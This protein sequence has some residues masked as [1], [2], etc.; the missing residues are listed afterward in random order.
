MEE[1]GRGH[2]WTQTPGERDFESAF[3]PFCFW[4]QCAGI[5]LFLMQGKD[6][7]FQKWFL[8]F[9][10]KVFQITSLLPFELIYLTFCH[11][12]N[13]LIHYSLITKK[14]KV[15]SLSRV[16][17]VVTPWTAAHQAPLSMGIFQARVL[18][19]VTISFSR[20][21]S[22]P[23]GWA[24]VS[25]IVDRGFTVWATREYGNRHKFYCCN[26]FLVTRQLSHIKITFSPYSIPVSRYS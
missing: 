9:W 5:W 22:L 25:R 11:K 6:V 14:V 8:F 24:W 21:S 20:E 13:L 3:Q 15:K 4:W 26:Q 10:F 12:S 16:W 17:L 18:E 1:L 7:K 23:R 19:W 2:S